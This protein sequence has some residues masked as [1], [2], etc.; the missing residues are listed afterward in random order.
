[1]VQP[2]ESLFLFQFCLSA[3]IYLP[4][5]L[6]PIPVAVEIPKEQVHCP[7][8]GAVWTVLQ[9][10]ARYR[11][12]LQHLGLSLCDKNFPS[13]WLW[14]NCLEVP[15]TA[16]PEDLA[17]SYPHG[18]HWASTGFFLTATKTWEQKRTKKTGTCPNR[19]LRI[20]GQSTLQ[21]GKGSWSFRSDVI[22]GTSA[23]RK[24]TGFAH[25]A[26]LVGTF[27]SWVAAFCGGERKDKIKE[28]ERTL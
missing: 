24:E 4:H 11:V 20:N 25:R 12:E 18:F 1:M 9:C 8:A 5:G 2:L 23:E 10:L 15:A 7:W 28:P 21:R 6:L 17:L 13:Q 27:V 3:E 14:V 22:C 16:C 26:V 19:T